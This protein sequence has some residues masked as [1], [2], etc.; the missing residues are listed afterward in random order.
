[1]HET[2]SKY[3][4]GRYLIFQHLASMSVHWYLENHLFLLNSGNINNQIRDV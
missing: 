2:E 1:M 3:Y 4:L